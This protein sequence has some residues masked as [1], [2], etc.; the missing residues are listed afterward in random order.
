MEWR[1][2]ENSLVIKTKQQYLFSLMMFGVAGIIFMF[3]T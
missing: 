3:I 1:N 2:Q